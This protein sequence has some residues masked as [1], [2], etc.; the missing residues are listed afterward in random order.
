MNLRFRAWATLSALA[1]L[2]CRPEFS[3]DYWRIEASRVLA[4][5]SEPAEAKPGMPL[6]FTAFLSEPG[7]P[8]ELPD[9]SFCTAPKPPTENNVVSAACLGPGSLI[10]AD[11]GLSIEGTLPLA[12]C[13]LFG[14]NSPPGNFRPRDPDISG[15]YYQP[16]RLDLAGS[17]PTFHLQR[18]ACD[19]ADASSDVAT[20]FGLSYVPN[21]NPRLSP[22]HATV[23]G[24][25]VALDHIPLGALVEL[26]V[27]WSASD[28]ESYVYFDRTL[29][30]LSQRREA[31][32]ASWYTNGGSLG[33]E[34]TGRSESDFAL[35]AQNHWTA[36]KHAGNFALW[37]VL[38]DS[39]GGVDFARY[40]LVVQ[41]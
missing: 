39:R 4:V 21:E 14:P 35:T 30:V 28:A 1:A 23:D 40:G 29:Q 3:D 15:G 5:K 24:R 27:S 19:L 34:S 20:Q 31:I 18:I 26:T 8:S 41:P 38:R 2:A 22:I 17:E 33:T 7:A 16:L 13:T 37:V 9:W 12:G 25:A 36:P 6:T 10:A 32:R 11:S